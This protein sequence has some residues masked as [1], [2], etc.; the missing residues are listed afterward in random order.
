MPRFFRLRLGRL[1]LRTFRLGLSHRMFW[2][3]GVGAGFWPLRL[4]HGVPNAFD[5]PRILLG[6]RAKVLGNRA[7]FL[8][9]ACAMQFLQ[10]ANHR[11]YPLGIGGLALDFPMGGL[12]S[13]L[14]CLGGQWKQHEPGDQN[15]KQLETRV[16]WFHRRWLC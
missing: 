14:L 11:L 7:G 16:G 4:L 8:G 13:R 3:F 5:Q 12:S 10:L 2:S 9:L 15:R 1:M 6:N